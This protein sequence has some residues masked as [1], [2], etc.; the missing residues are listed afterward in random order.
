MS[1]R[2]GH[3][4]P[5]PLIS[6]PDLDSK[7]H[8][9]IACAVEM[10]LV[11]NCFIRAINSIF[12]YAPYVSEPRDIKDFLR[13]CQAFVSEISL[14]H[15]TEEDI[16]F[17][18]WVKASNTPD[19][20]NENIEEHKTFEEGLHQLKQYTQN[21]ESQAYRSEDLL[22]I[23]DQ[24]IPILVQHLTSEIDSI[25]AMR[26]Y[27]GDKILAT[28]R[29]GVNAAAAAATKDEQFPFALGCNDVT[30]EGGKH[31]FPDVPWILIA[32]VKYWFA[33]T[34]KGAW[35]FCPSDMGGQPRKPFLGPNA[36]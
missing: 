4:E 15:K 25:L 12:Y 21:T 3:R 24:F 26:K 10:T 23:M 5:L 17:P 11:H 34:H 6:T 30:F 35:R 2:E 22:A 14:H 16:I 20:M 27:D 33:R 32:V 1:P 18:M 9:A 28:F 7:E 31:K 36:Q 8:G 19:L 29:D 13:F